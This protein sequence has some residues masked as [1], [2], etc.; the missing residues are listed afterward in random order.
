[1]QYPKAYINPVIVVNLG[2]QEN[3]IIDMHTADHY[4]LHITRMHIL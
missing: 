4:P 3:H 2:N 1:M